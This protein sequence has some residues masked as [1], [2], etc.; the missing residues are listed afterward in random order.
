MRLMDVARAKRRAGRIASTGPRPKPGKPGAPKG[1]TGK[2]NDATMARAQRAMM[3][4]LIVA[5]VGGLEIGSRF[6]LGGAIFGAVAGLVAVFALV[7]VAIAIATFGCRLAGRNPR[8]MEDR[9]AF[10]STWSVTATAAAV[11]S[12]AIVT[13]N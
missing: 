4:G 5:F 10:W 1:R 3:I 13:S 9:I 8:E 12:A 7:P 11:A 2:A 6:G